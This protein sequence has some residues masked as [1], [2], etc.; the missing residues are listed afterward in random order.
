MSAKPQTYMI[1]GILDISYFFIV[2][3]SYI[4]DVF[5]YMNKFY[6][7]IFRITYEFHEGS[8]LARVPGFYIQF[9]DF[10]CAVRS[11]MEFKEICDKY[12]SFY[13]AAVVYLSITMFCMLLVLYGFVHFMAL[14]LNYKKRWI[15]NLGCCHYLYPILHTLAV[16]LYVWV[17]GY[18]K[19]T[20]PTGFGVD[21]Q[22]NA[23]AGLFLMLFAEVVSV[24]GMF[25]YLFSSMKSKREDES[26]TEEYSA[27]SYKKIEDTD[28]TRAQKLPILPVS[29]TFHSSSSESSSPKS[30][31]KSFKLPR[32][33]VKKVIEENDEESDSSSDREES[34]ENPKKNSDSSSE[35]SI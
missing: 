30:S 19:L 8:L 18:Y 10:F 34:K 31:K 7:S 1:I 21:F 28:F 33:E 24:S 27:D 4:A 26:D 32:D 20:Q 17:S 3:S 14:S 5:Q 12:S 29:E 16:L 2:L 13:N 35:D 25:I 15:C 11:N 23:R 6:M 22:P 9:N